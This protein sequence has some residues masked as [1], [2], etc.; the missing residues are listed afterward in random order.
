MVRGWPYTS[1]DVFWEH[2]KMWSF[3]LE[4]LT[5]ELD[6]T[7]CY[8]ACCTCT[9]HVN[10]QYI[11]HHSGVLY[12]HRNNKVSTSSIFLT[13]LT[14][15]WNT[16]SCHRITPVAS[17]LWHVASLRQLSVGG[18]DQPFWNRMEWHLWGCVQYCESRMR[19][20]I[21]MAKNIC[22]VLLKESFSST[23]RWLIM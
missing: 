7:I 18:L 6:S 14:G 16:P 4:F 20:Y 10:L 23:Y 9:V 8:C 19:L 13:S 17:V 2:L 5:L 1:L 21:S 15:Q 11:S 3:V 22:Q 12:T